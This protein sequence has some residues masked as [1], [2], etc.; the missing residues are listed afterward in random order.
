MPS[1]SNLADILRGWQTG[2]KPVDSHSGN[3]TDKI[4]FDEKNSRKGY[5]VDL[6]KKVKTDLEIYI[7][8]EVMNNMSVWM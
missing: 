3:H 7:A 4:H 6:M 1:A 2:K 8:N 5:L